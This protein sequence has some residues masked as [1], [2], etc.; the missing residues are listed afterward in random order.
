MTIVETIV[1]FGIMV[2]LA[3]LPSASVVL[4]ITRSAT[5]GVGNGIASSL[6]IV[7]GDLVF[8]FLTM[9]GLSYIA[10]SMGMLFMFI[11][12]LGAFY[13]VWLGLSML[14]S[15]AKT[16]ISLSLANSNK[17]LFA[18]FFAGLLLTLGDIK[19][20]VFY[21][22]L[23]PVFIDLSALSTV[24]ISIVVTVTIIAVGGVKVI[25]AL[26][27]SKIAHFSRMRKV[28][29]VSQKIAGGILVGAGGYLAVKS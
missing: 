1:L 10:E 16:E 8:I 19:A 29:G 2:T 4:V 17:N 26:S 22:S 24:D 7:L 23:L 6:G 12:Y 5:L 18:S 11:K 13:L 25:Y 9:V 15:K 21:I 27:A 20:I 14:T 3:A 28:E